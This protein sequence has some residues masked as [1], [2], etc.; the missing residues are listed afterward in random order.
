MSD[1]GL[2]VSL[3]RDPHSGVRVLVR[4]ALMA[5]PVRTRRCEAELK[6]L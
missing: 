1:A 3:E 4:W 6:R 5:W 2:K